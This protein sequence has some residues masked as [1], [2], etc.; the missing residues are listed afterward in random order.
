M[1]RIK[2]VQ[3]AKE[4]NVSLETCIDFLH[5]R[6]IEVDRNNINVRIDEQDA[7]LLYQ[8]FG[9]YCEAKNKSNL[10]IKE[11]REA[12]LIYKGEPI[13]ELW[14]EYNERISQTNHSISNNLTDQ[15]II[16][17]NNDTKIKKFAVVSVIVETIESDFI[18]VNIDNSHKKGVIKK[19][20]LY[21]YTETPIHVGMTI[22][23]K[24]I[25]I[26]DSIIIL[27]QKAVYGRMELDFNKEN[28]YIIDT[29][30]FIQ[31]PDIIALIGNKYK[32]I[33][34]ATVITEIDF[35]K[36]NKD[37][38]VS[39]AARTSLKCIDE[40]LSFPNNVSSEQFDKRYMPKD[41]D[42]RY[43]DDKILTIAIKIAK[44]G[45]NPI[46]MSSDI[47]LH[48]KAK[49]NSITAITLDDFLNQGF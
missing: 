34:P 44:T 41:L 37:I 33:I 29:N 35:H 40:A 17:N 28:V 5:T 20:D 19:E 36:K 26:H 15:V 38:N 47:G 11:K 30:V 48:A 49:A 32:I 16:P 18:T 24:I 39:M 8:Q 9:S 43:N 12:G 14:T 42:W 1:P 2:L 45:L 25:A 4:I 6:N 21:S 46:V 3:V 23:A 7:D 13:M 31:R 10:I 27:S 22:M